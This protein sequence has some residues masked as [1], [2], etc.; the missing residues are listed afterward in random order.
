MDNSDQYL[1]KLS[2]MTEKDRL[3]EIES[4]KSLCICHKCNIYNDCAKSINELAYCLI[5]KSP[6]CILPGDAWCVC[7]I[8]PL[9]KEFG[10]MNNT[11]CL[12]D[13]EEKQRKE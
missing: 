1:E 5:G 4:K 13:S 7:G 2:K 8:C 11:F 6:K 9:T 3:N 12:E 10:L